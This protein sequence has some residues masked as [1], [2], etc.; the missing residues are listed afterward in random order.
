M[1]LTPTP[2]SQEY[3]EKAQ[4]LENAALI[5]EIKQLIE[6]KGLTAELV[7]NTPDTAENQQARQYA[8]AGCSTCTLCPCMIC[9]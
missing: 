7:D 1:P 9:W 6:R 5:D 4:A 2:R 8:V 3:D